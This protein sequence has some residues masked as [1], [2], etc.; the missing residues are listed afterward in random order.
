MVVLLQLIGSLKVF[1]QPYIMTGGGP[2]NSTRVVLHYMYETGFVNDNA[3]YASAIAVVFMV[4][5]LL[6]SLVQNWLL[7]GRHAA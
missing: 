7:R 6:V 1:S 5:V 3:G 4:V 2:F